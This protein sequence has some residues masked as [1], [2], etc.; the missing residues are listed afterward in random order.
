MQDNTQLIFGTF[1]LVAIPSVS[2][3]QPF[4]SLPA[5]RPI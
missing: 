1:H 4:V 3:S 2:A 5:S